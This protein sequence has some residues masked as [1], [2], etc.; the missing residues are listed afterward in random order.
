MDPERLESSGYAALREFLREHSGWVPI[1]EACLTVAEQCNGEFAGAWV[2]NEAQKSGIG[3]FPNLRP[4]VVAGILRRV[5][6][7]RGGRR[8]YYMI[9]DREAVEQ[10]LRETQSGTRA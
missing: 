7:T 9:L 8:G 6:V 10:A 3:W 1:V 2:L 4:L 5:D